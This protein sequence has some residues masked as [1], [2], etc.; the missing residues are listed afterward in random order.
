MASMR[1]V[2]LGALAASPDYDYTYNDNRNDD[3]NYE[4]ENQWVCEQIEDIEGGCG[5]RND[6]VDLEV[7]S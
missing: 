6:D 1:S 5:Y 4:E 3:H 2:A 7:S